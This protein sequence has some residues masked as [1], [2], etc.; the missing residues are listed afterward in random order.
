V[1][2]STIVFLWKLGGEKKMVNGI[3]EGLWMH[4]FNR[5]GVGSVAGFDKARTSG[6]SATYNDLEYGVIEVKVLGFFLRLEVMGRRKSLQIQR[7]GGNVQIFKRTKVE[8]HWRL[9]FQS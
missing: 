8:G 2:V 1:Y 9:S 5:V 3:S 4:C 6:M 7:R